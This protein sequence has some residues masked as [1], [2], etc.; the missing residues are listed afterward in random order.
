MTSVLEAVIDASET[1]PRNRA[2]RGSF[3]SIRMERLG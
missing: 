3:V 1:R 2:V